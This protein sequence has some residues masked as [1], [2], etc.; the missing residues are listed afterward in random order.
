MGMDEYAD[1]A[2]NPRAAEAGSPTEAVEEVPK[3][4]RSLKE[5]ILHLPTR[6]GKELHVGTIWRLSHDGTQ[7]AMTMDLEKDPQVQGT[8]HGQPGGKCRRIWGAGKEGWPRNPPP[9]DMV[10]HR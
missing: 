2:L 3:P 9:N 5:A 7:T 10:V 1:I 4:L 8:P 6:V